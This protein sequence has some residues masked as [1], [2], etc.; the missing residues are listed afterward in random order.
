MVVETDT[1]GNITFVNE[2]VRK[3][4]S[5]TKSDFKKGMTIFDIIVPEEHEKLKKRFEKRRSW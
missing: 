5:F 1:T 4:F 2:A 3:N